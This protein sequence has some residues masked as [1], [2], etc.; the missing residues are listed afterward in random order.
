[1]LI[2]EHC[3]FKLSCATVVAVGNSLHQYVRMNKSQQQNKFERAMLPDHL[4]S[5]WSGHETRQNPESG[6]SVG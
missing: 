4:L 5:V 2:W 3:Y 6:P 1:M